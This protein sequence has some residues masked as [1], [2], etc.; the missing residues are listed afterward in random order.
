MFM[1]FNHDLTIT[2]SNYVVQRRLDAIVFYEKY[3]LKPT[4]DAFNISKSTLYRWRSSYLNSRRRVH[5]LEPKS[6]KPNN[7][8]RMKIDP[9]IL[10]FIKDIR[11]IH[12][13]M[14]KAK[15]K[16]LLDEYCIKYKIDKVSESLIGKI[17]KRNNYF[18][19]KTGKVYHDPSKGRRKNKKKKKRLSSNYISKSPGELIQ[20]DTIVTFDMGLKRYTLTAIDIYSRFGFALT[21]KSLSSK[22]ALDFFLRLKHVFPGTIDSVKTDNGLEFHK[23]FDQYLEDNN[24]THYFSYPRSPKSNAYVERFNRTI[25]EEFLYQNLEYIDDTTIFN[26]KLIEY[27]IFYNTVRPHYGIN[28]MTPMGLITSINLSTKESHMCVT[29]TWAI[30]YRLIKL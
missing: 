21:Y 25:Q 1:K 4:L 19:Y 29:Y 3:G 14:G 30:N 20:I 11:E 13:T 8:R 5:S 9:L 6:T 17:I 16:P 22:I 24:I 7:T 18:F 27:L 28:M 2:Q 15:I 10:D 26:Q 23:L 12:P